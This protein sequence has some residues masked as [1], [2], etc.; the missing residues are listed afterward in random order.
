M[1]VEEPIWRLENPFCLIDLTGFA[2]FFLFHGI[3]ASVSELD[4]HT[5][6]TLLVY[7]VLRHPKYEHFGKVIA[8]EHSKTGFGG[9]SSLTTI[10]Y[11]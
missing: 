6:K 7:K 4:C 11:Q 3:F 9:I 1:H 10:M 2:L 8:K 5:F